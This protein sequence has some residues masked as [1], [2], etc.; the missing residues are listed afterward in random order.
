MCRI[1]SGKRAGE[2]F[3]WLENGA[4]LYVCGAK[5][6]SEDVEKT[7]IELVKKSGTREHAE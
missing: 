1:K 4:T 6:M 2:F 5:R 3:R 7:I